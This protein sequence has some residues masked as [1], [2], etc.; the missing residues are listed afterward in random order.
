MIGLMP[1][2]KFHLLLLLTTT[3]KSVTRSLGLWPFR[4]GRDT[5]AIQSIE[6]HEPSTTQFPHH[7]RLTDKTSVDEPRGYDRDDDRDIRDDRR[8]NEDRARSASPD[9]RERMDTR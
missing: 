9:G 4:E 7:G 5:T 3:W 2:S 8:A 6:N 1:V